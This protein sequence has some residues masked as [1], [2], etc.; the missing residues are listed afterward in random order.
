MG[1]VCVADTAMSPVL[2][3]LAGA[4]ETHRAGDQEAKSQIVKWV[5]GGENS[6]SHSTQCLLPN[7]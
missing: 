1:A 5:W 2:G 7:I 3:A 4:E 6:L